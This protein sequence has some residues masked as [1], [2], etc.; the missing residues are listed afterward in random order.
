MFTSVALSVRRPNFLPFSAIIESYAN[1]L[2][3]S[4]VAELADKR[5]ASWVRLQHV[6]EDFGAS[7][8][9]GDAA[10]LADL[11][12]SRTQLVLRTY[13]SQLKQW[14]EKTPPGIL[15]GASPTTFSDFPPNIVQQTV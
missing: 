5:L 15:N 14:R 7:L 8:A 1:F 4:P 9:F 12:D 11:R 3:N 13:G 10:V 2:E 6:A